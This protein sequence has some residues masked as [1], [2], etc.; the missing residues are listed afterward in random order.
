M[1]IIIKDMTRKKQMFKCQDCGKDTEKLLLCDKCFEKMFEFKKSNADI[2][3]EI[4]RELNKTYTKKNND[5]GD[6]F[7]KSYDEFG[8][9]SAIVRMTDKMERLKTLTTGTKKEVK[10]ESIEDT[11]LDLANYAIMTVIEMRN[12]R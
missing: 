1:D 9:V 7:K 10:D 8:I 12:R 2:H 5:Y 4:C 3:A 11:L 6:S